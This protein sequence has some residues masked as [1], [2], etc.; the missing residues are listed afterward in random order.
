MSSKL[1]TNIALVPPRHPK[2]KRKIHLAKMPGILPYC[3]GRRSGKGAEYQEDFCGL[4]A[5]T[6]LACLRI[7]VRKLHGKA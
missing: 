4:S 2:V 6:C 1:L 7:A 5:V 3:G